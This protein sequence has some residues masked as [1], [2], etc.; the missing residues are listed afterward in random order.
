M[1]VTYRIDNGIAN[2]TFDGD[3]PPDDVIQTFGRVLDDPACPRRFSLLV[4]VSASSSLPVRAT[5]DIVRVAEALGPHKDR[6]VRC[7]VLAAGDL[8][9][10]LSRM[11]AVYSE[12][13]GVMTNVFRE[14]D[15]ALAWL[16]ADSPS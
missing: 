4:D 7:A 5:E 11:G 1:P 13:G 3:C 10:G 15:A 8:H 16:R 12:A 6:V 14:R 9:F 2:M